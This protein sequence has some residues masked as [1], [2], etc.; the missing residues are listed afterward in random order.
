MED[1][2]QHLPTDEKTTNTPDEMAVIKILTGSAQPAATQPGPGGS[3][4]VASELLNVAVV[5]A[6][7]A[8]ISSEFF[9]ALIARVVPLSE[10]KWYVK[11]AIRTVLF[12]VMYFLIT[13]FAL[14]RKCK[15][16]TS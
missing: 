11:L 1:A 2:L 5:G 12:V 9:G 7:F 16:E 15:Q 4:T 14:S 3:P 6:L 8:V 13:N 10:E